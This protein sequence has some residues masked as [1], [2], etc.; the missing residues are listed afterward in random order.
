MSDSE[1]EVSDDISVASGGSDGYYDFDERSQASFTSKASKVSKGSMGGKRKKSPKNSA[2]D[3]SDDYGDYS[4]DFV[5]DFEA[6]ETSKPPS[7]RG[8]RVT[9]DTLLPPKSSSLSKGRDAKG[10]ASPR[11]AP[12]A[13]AGD[14]VLAAK[15]AAARASQ[16][17]PAG[18]AGS[19]QHLPSLQQQSL[20]TEMVLE[21]ISK[22]IIAM[23]NMQ[24][25]QLKER[26]AAAKEK[27][28]R[29]EERR[30]AYEQRL[31]EAEDTR[32][33]AL[34]AEQTHA[35]QVKA[36]ES[37]IRSLTESKDVVISSLH[38]IEGDAEKL[39][40]N[41]AAVN[42]ELRKAVEENN[43]LSLKF[44]TSRSDWGDR[45]ATL[46]AEVKKYSMLQATVQRSIEASEARFAKER[47]NLPA[48]QA[49]ALKEQ[50]DRLQMLEGMLNEREG[51]LRQQEAY[52]LAAVEN[53]RKESREELIRMRS[54]VDAELALEKSEAH[55]LLAS[56]RSERAQWDAV[57]AQEAANVDQMKLGIARQARELSERAASLDKQ[58][59][60]F[61]GAR[62][63]IQPTLD[64]VARDRN[65]AATLKEQADRV[66]LAAE[67]HTSSILA[68][69]RGL[70]RREQ[71]LQ[72]QEYNIKQV[73]ASLV[74]QRKALATEQAR[75]KFK[76]QTVETDRFRLH[77]ASMDLAAQVSHVNRESM[78]IS[79]QL[80]Q[81]SDKGGKKEE[82]AGAV[83][84]G[85]KYRENEFD[86]EN[87]ENNSRQQQQQ[88][89]A[90][91]AHD[92][93][94]SSTQLSLRGVSASLENILHSTAA[95]QDADDSN[96][97]GSLGYDAA[98][99][100]PP[101]PG[102]NTHTALQIL[103]ERLST[104]GFPRE[105]PAQ[106][107]KV[108]S[109]GHEDLRSSLEGVCT[110][111]ANMMAVASRYGVYAKINAGSF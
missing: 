100:L 89:I 13:A 60:E 78:Q 76:R 67:E 59:A 46:Q 62:R 64:A 107:S 9:L 92:I 50:Q 8:S 16:S 61:E 71:E 2:K 66:L 90:Q 25:Q 6:D 20:Q 91:N 15:L 12:P 74:A 111:S 48:Y 1:S 39:R 7:P 106:R 3:V 87:V 21:D 5:D 63:M 42:K 56:A 69:E 65:D 102:D 95:P 35:M 52:K 10:I 88:Y 32:V 54:K 14:G 82:Q 51:A 70:V 85:S 26:Q 53:M 105:L 57:K 49:Q 94:Y 101:P 36:L 97:Y 80:I 79:R 33:Q 29:A 45:E 77:Q 38:A 58:Q 11:N 86:D 98:Y 109:L 19:G 110:S 24:R 84:M 41:L 81:N 75:I 55:A 40:N 4:N 18:A 27:R 47:E 108:A 23:R 30:R 22:E 34:A 68:A 37:Q 43:A 73:Q 104:I 93:S 99:S 31:Q 72:K 96:M 28:A 17:A 103:D 83:V 44:N